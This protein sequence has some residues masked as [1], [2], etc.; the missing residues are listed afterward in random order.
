MPD[1]FEPADLS[2]I[3]TEPL[4]RRVHK[5]AV[6][7]FASPC[8]E[9]G[10]LAAFL[11][12]LS[13]VLA[14]RELRGLARAVVAARAGG[15]PV[16]WAMGA[17]P[18]K[19][20][21]SPL[22]IQLMR[23]GAISALV[24]NG[25]GAIHDW[26]IAAVGSTSE[27]VGPGL[28]EGLFGVA[29]ETGRELSEAAREAQRRHEGLGQALARRAAAAGLPHARHSLLATAGELDLP[30]LVHVAIGSDTVH[31]HPAAD[32]AAIGEASLQDFRRLCGL[33]GRAEGG[34]W[35][36]CGSAVLLP[37]VFLKALNAARNLGHRVHSL[38]TANLDMQRHYRVERN[39]LE[40]PTRRGGRSFNLIGHHEI[41]VPLLAAAILLESRRENLCG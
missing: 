35:I 11:D 19:V 17:H 39:V 30:L 18:V 37:E 4:A 27:E 12:G 20:G 26:E 40:R 1:P 15:R 21:V 13:D 32:G 5:V 25:A 29:E 9:G 2:R 36:N 38:T 33:L 24:L 8:Q 10:S 34:V 41:N 16:V 6:D 31:T 22:L 14:V 7:A 23:R 3:R 28:D